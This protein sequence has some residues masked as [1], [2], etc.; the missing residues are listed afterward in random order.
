[1]VGGFTKALECHINNVP[2]SGVHKE[3]A[4]FYHQYKI[5]G[6]ISKIPLIGMPPGHLFKQHHLLNLVPEDMRP[7]HIDDFHCHYCRDWTF[8][9]TQMVMF[10]DVCLQQECLVIVDDMGVHSLGN[11]VNEKVTHFH[12]QTKHIQT[13]RLRHLYWS[14]FTEIL[15]VCRVLGQSFSVHLH[16]SPNQHKDIAGIVSV[17]QLPVF[18]SFFEQID[19][20]IFQIP[21]NM[22]HR[23]LSVLGYKIAGNQMNDTGE[24]IVFLKP[25]QGKKHIQ[26][27]HKD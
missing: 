13:Q 18:H 14:I 11:R 5:L 8:E 27:Y 3:D 12:D 21:A 7:P 9:R 16:F 2:L 4:Y 24:N 6:E 17:F 25:S 15:S 20:L 26:I 19:Q 10:E 23:A 1:M 22:T